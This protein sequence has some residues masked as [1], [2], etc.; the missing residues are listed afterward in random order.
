[1]AR[2]DVYIMSG[3]ASDLGDD[4]DE[5]D[6]IDDSAEG[7]DSR[8]RRRA[9]ALHLACTRDPPLD[10]VKRLIDANPEALSTP[11][12][13]GWE[14]PLHYAVGSGMA[15]D[16]VINAL[17]EAYPDAADKVSTGAARFGVHSSPLHLAVAAFLQGDD[18]P[19]SISVLKTMCRRN[20]AARKVRDASN[21]TPLEL[22]DAIQRPAPCPQDLKKI[23]LP[24]NDINEMIVF[25]VKTLLLAILVVGAAW[26]L[27]KLEHF[28]AAMVDR[29]EETF[30][31]VVSLG[32]SGLAVAFCICIIALLVVNTTRIIQQDKAQHP[33]GEEDDDS[34]SDEFVTI[35]YVSAVGLIVLFATEPVTLLLHTTVV[36]GCALGYILVRRS[37]MGPIDENAN[38]EFLDCREIHGSMS[39]SSLKDS[40]ARATREYDMTP[41]ER[42]GM[43]IVCWE[44]P[45]DHVLVPCGHLCLCAECPRHLGDDLNW[46]CP[47]G[48]CAVHAAMKVFP[49]QIKRNDDDDDNGDD[50][51]QPCDQDDKD[52]DDDGGAPVG[53]VSTNDDDS[54]I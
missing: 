51:D 23:L 21:R 29:A 30:A 10:V 7:A 41:L 16:S 3:S 38:S 27:K 22:A 13:L 4:E 24:S 53:A 14:Y 44:R 12:S 39:D 2:H 52:E 45:A 9:T 25:R 54:N 6:Y 42:D 32:S 34:T 43:C 48:K 26:F 33:L 5:A 31:E 49:A 50:A 35:L 37:K 28:G 18:A 36:T 1:V 19:P 8:H 15:S 20:P 17:T 47:I 11:T 40:A 46:Q